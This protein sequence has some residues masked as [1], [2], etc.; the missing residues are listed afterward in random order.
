M[1]TSTVTIAGEKKTPEYP[2]LG[3]SSVSKLIVLFTS[4]GTG[5]VVVSDEVNS[6]GEFKKELWNMVKF[7]PLP[8][9]S[10]VTLTQGK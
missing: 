2:H 3:K 7:I 8:A 1:I 5:T 10:F 4:Y 9:K 6:L